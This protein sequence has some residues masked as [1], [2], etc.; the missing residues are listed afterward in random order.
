MYTDYI[1]NNPNLQPQLTKFHSAAAM[2][3][4]VFTSRPTTL[5]APN[6]LFLIF[7]FISNNL[8]STVA[9]PWLR[10]L[11]IGLLLQRV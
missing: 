8:P 2:Q 9:V 4:A 3:Y 6:S 11:V 5:P 10:K 7:T 1:V